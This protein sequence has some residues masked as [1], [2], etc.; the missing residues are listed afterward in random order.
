M[1]LLFASYQGSLA[2]AQTPNHSPQKQ[3]RGKSLCNQK[4]E[5]VNLHIVS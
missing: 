4:R 1:I 3:N 2:T 5:Q